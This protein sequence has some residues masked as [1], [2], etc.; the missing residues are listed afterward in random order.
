MTTHSM[1]GSSV[2]VLILNSSVCIQNAMSANRNAFILP[3]FLAPFLLFLET[4]HF[5]ILSP[6]ILIGSE[7]DDRNP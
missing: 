4:D 7:G 5:C 6:Y 3:P 2:A 1:H